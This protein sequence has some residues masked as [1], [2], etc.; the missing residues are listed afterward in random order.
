ME[1]GTTTIRRKR[2]RANGIDTFASTPELVGIELM[3]AFGAANG[4]P[5]LA[6]Q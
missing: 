2:A 1:L 3:T 4:R 5:V 6:A